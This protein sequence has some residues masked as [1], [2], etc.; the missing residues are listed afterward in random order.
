MRKRL[1]LLAG[2]VALAATLALPAAEPVAAPTCATDV[3]Y[4]P[5]GAV[6][7]TGF[8]AS[9]T[10][11]RDRRYPYTFTTSGRLGIPS[12]IGNKRGC[13]GRVQVRY[14][15]KKVTVSSRTAFVHVRGGRCVYTSR[16]TYKW[17]RRIVLL[18]GTPIHYRVTVRY[19]GSR[20]IRTV[21][22]K[23]YTVIAG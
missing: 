8:S 12:S 18:G 9:T 3:T 23:P 5:T 14:K 11:R 2:P 21:A 1:V 4:C 6:N 20:Y 15:V 10:P 17:L 16:V 19:L 7:P 22:H 13:T